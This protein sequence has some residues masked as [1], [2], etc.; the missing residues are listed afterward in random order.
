MTPQTYIDTL[1]QLDASRNVQS[2]DSLRGVEG[3]EAAALVGEAGL[4]RA[5]LLS[6]WEDQQRAFATH[7]QLAAELRRL[8]SYG[9]MKAAHWVAE[10]LA[11][12]DDKHLER[13]T[14]RRRRQARGRRG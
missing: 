3:D 14:G 7:V 10:H 11:L 9:V 5:R 2:D 4:D 6:A 8:A 13:P 12:F 1:R